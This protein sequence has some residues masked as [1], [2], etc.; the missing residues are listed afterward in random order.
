M[1]LL[2]EIAGKVAEAFTC[3][4]HGPRDDE[5]PLALAQ[6]LLQRLSEHDVDAPAEILD[7]ASADDASSVLLLAAALLHTPH[8]KTL[9]VRATRRATTT[10]DPQLA[11]VAGAVTDGDRD[12]LDVLLSEHL[13]DFPDSPLGR[14]IAEQPLPSGPTTPAHRAEG[15]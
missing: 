12:R 1:N 10:P 11:A 8:D 7:R 15:H 9:V 14:W 4:Y 13:A 6:D 3:L 5:L 2:R